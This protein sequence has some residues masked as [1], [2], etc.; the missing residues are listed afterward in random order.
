MRR[1][2]PVDIGL[3][4]GPHIPAASLEFKDPETEKQF[5]QCLVEGVEFRVSGSLCRND[6][7]THTIME[8]RLIPP[9]TLPRGESNAPEAR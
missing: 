6:D 4:S 3:H 2:V 8:L 1:T 9:P 5:A 7:G